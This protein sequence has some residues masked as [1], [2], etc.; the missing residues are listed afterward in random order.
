MIARND[1]AVRH[2]LLPS[3][4]HGYDSLRY[5]VP[6]PVSLGDVSNQDT[7]LIEDLAHTAAGA[8]ESTQPSAVAQA[9]YGGGT[10]GVIPP[11]VNAGSISFGGSTGI[12]LLIGVGFLALAFAGRRGHR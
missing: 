2:G 1:T 12:V 4:L 9:I 11:G 8:F 6:T 10:S 7:G 3:G 5:P